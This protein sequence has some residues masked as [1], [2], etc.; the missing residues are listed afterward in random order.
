MRWEAQLALGEAALWTLKLYPEAG[1]AGGCRVSVRGAGRGRPSSPDRVEAEAAR[2]AKG[3]IRRYCAANRLN[4]LG[5]LT[6]RADGCY[7][8]KALRADV[9]RFFR[10]LRSDLDR[11]PFPYL[12]VPEWHP[13]GHGLHVHF[14]VGR[15][16]KHS[17]IERNWARGRVHIK[18]IGGLTV[19]P[20]A[21]EQARIA[22]RY[23]G[24]Y[25][26]KSL[27][28]GRVTGLHRYEVA[29]GFQPAS[30]TCYGPTAAQAIE[31]ASTYMG[32][33]PS[34]CWFSSLS[35]GWHGPPACWV[36]WD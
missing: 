29:Q 2:R 30:I 19:G 11:E 8:P 32:A 5:T 35:E 15:Y 28:E 36:A 22:G 13:G 31:T 14:A 1:E 7:D 6:Y 26:A 4:R 3:R 20:G 25:A 23:L 9:S 34:Q 10:S 17:L 21:I 27:D 18:L 16:I 12:W 33:S 24:K